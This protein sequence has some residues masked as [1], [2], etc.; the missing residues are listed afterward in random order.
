MKILLIGKNGQVG[1]ELNKLLG[2]LGILIALTREELDFAKPNSIKPIILDIRPDIII[3]AAAYTAVDK[4]EEEPEL[5]MTINGVAP[6]ILAKTAKIV[7]A[8]LIHYST[9]YVFDGHSNVAYREENP[10]CPL[11]VYGKSKL[12]GE[13]AIGEV[14]I[15]YLIF[16]TGW[17][18]SLHG[19]SFLKTIKTM[20]ERKD[21]LTIVNDQIGSPTW[22]RSIALATHQILE[23]CLQKNWL[24]KNNP[25]LSGVFHLTC[26]GKTSWHGF[27]KEIL[28][29]SGMESTVLIPISTSDYPTTAIRPLF[30]LLCNEKIKNTFNTQ[31]PHW[32]EAL[33]NCL[34]SS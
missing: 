23:Q 18:Y 4:A 2:R 21:K 7:G 20:A 9:D 15:P 13:K 33:K 17:I 27:A 26:Q 16:R 30:S 1:L 25:S 10:T 31:L 24:K 3:N 32:Q 22:A 8:G 14:Q 6:G 11:S 12:A 19:K 29:L 5:A 28:S 34:I